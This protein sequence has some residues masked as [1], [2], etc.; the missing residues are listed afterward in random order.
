MNL[1]WDRDG[2]RLLVHEDRNRRGRLLDGVTGEP[3]A[4]LWDGDDIRSRNAVFVASGELAIARSGE[5]NS[6]IDV[7][8]SD[9]SLVHS[10]ELPTSLCIW[11][12]GEVE[13]GVL[14]V[15][16][17][18]CD[19]GWRR[20]D[21]FRVDV[22]RGDATK[23]ASGMAPVSRYPLHHLAYHTPRQVPGSPATKLFYEVASGSLV[24]LDP[25]TGEREFLLGEHAAGRG[26]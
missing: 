8:D 13:P 12:G 10:I 21:I 15:A 14:F 20:G 9:G 5:A 16:L 1:D 22:G 19:A 23:L 24:R 3:I 7:H 25:R 17:Y 11:Y 4:T 6:R 2:S 18:N 26:R